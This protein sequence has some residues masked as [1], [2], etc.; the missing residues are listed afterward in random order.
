MMWGELL[1]L[2]EAE[3]NGS[4]SRG[5]GAKVVG[6]PNGRSVSTRS[7]RTGSAARLALSDSL[8]TTAGLLLL[9]SALLGYDI[10]LLVTGQA[11]GMTLLAGA[12]GIV[13][14]LGVVSLGAASLLVRRRRL[15]AAETRESR[16]DYGDLDPD[17]HPEPPLLGGGQGNDTFGWPRI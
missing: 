12:A 6:S 16:G 14:A 4:M 8:M 5:R 9:P 10:W 3:G 15:A 2:E 17:S 7:R 11:A 1:P 13:C